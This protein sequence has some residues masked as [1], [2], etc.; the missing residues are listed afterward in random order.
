MSCSGASSRVR[1][2]CT[3]SAETFC[4]IAAQFERS[5]RRDVCALRSFLV[6]PAIRISRP[7]KRRLN[8]AIWR[9]E[10][11]STLVT[12]SCDCVEIERFDFQGA[13]GY[14]LACTLSI[15]ECCFYTI[16]TDHHCIEVYDAS[17]G[18]YRR[19]FGS[20]YGQSFVYFNYPSSV[21]VSDANELYVCDSG[22]NRV[23]VLDA[24]TGALIRVIG[25][26]ERGERGRLNGPIDVAVS[27]ERVYVCDPNNSG[28]RVFR[29]SDGVYLF[30]FGKDDC[31]L[32]RS[33]AVSTVSGNVYA[34]DCFNA[35]NCLK[36]RVQVFDADGKFLRVVPIPRH[37]HASE[38]FVSMHDELYVT[39]KNNSS[40]LVFGSSGAFSLTHLR[41]IDGVRPSGLAF[42]RDGRLFATCYEGVR[43]FE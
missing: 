21:Y 8:S 34:A 7:R 25:T 4:H 32:V 13:R 43:V 42:A 15:D 14:Y 38:V 5:V 1:A 36:T 37:V 2:T 29:E 17:S 30:S 33:I 11:A 22:N 16:R 9:Q 28:V 19:S 20:W 41:T 27:R 3:L 40:I 12:F 10:R 31:K 35:N 23:Q 39:D 6:W 18:A 24:V 26:G